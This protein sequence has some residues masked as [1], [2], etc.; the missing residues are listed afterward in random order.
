MDIDHR[1]WNGL[2]ADAGPAL[3]FRVVDKDW[4]S[5]PIDGRFVSESVI[6]RSRVGF[7][8][9]VGEN[10]ATKERDEP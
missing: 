10:K 6:T 5:V 1:R 9:A 2:T 3:K 8:A 4:S 7:T